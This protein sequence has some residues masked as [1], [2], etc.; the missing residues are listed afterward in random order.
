M[1]V[2]GGWAG[3]RPKTESKASGGTL[4]GLSRYGIA[5]SW[6]ARRARA[7]ARADGGR[8][9]S[10]LLLASPMDFLDLCAERCVGGNRPAG[11]GFLCG[12]GVALSLAGCGERA[13]A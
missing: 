13:R 9:L 6:P 2:V 5:C 11:F 4:K 10:L 1:V 12:C 3:A 7:R 8:P